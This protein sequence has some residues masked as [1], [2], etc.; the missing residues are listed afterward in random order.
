MNPEVQTTDETEKTIDV[1]PANPLNDLPVELDKCDTLSSVNQLEA[2]YIVPDHTWTGE[3]VTAIKQ[4]CEA[5]R[6]E[7]RAKRGERSN[8]AALNLGEGNAP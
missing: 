5:R 8:Q 4:I 3:Q 2:S 6:G 1:D 7:I